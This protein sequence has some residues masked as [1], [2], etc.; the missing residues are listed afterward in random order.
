MLIGGIFGIVIGLIIVSVMGFWFS[1]FFLFQT[2]KELLIKKECDYEGLRKVIM[3][4]VNGNAVTNGAIHMSAS[5]CLEEVD[6]NS[7]LIFSVTSP[8]IR[9]KDI[10]FEW[11]NFDTLTIQYNKK[12]EIIKQITVSNSINPK[13][14]F[15]Y[16]A[17]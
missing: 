11:K 10:D 12:L 1:S 13:I 2:P 14:T 15:E 5:H 3:Y 6:A 4:E 17:Q 9:S 8:N 7:E 16:I